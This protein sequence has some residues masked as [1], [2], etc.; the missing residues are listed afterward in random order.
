MDMVVCI[1]GH[2]PDDRLRYINIKRICTIKNMT[3][4]CYLHHGNMIRVLMWVYPDSADIRYAHRAFSWNISREH[5]LHVYTQRALCFQIEKHIRRK[6]FV[7]WN[8]GNIGNAAVYGIR[9]Y[10][11]L[12]GNLGTVH[13]LSE[14]EVGNTLHIQTN[15]ILLDTQKTN[16]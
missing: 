16:Q 4:K 11:L 15:V 13:Y 5:G 12:L 9:W 3:A 2:Y 1:C 7:N 6:H 10:T 8:W 14:Y